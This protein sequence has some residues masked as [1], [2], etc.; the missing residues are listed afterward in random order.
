MRIK[1]GFE[2]EREKDNITKTVDTM[3]DKER[4]LIR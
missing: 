4:D 2:V 1:R 3:R